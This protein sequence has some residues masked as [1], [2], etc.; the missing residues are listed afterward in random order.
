M[1]NIRIEYLPTS[2]LKEY[3]KNARK[4]DDYDIDKIVASIEEFGFNDPIG[5]WG[6]QNVIV[7]GHGRL[8]AAK[9][10]GMD[11]V[12]CIHLDHLSDA[13]RKAYA[14]AHNKTAEL[15]RWDFGR[16][17]EELEGLADDFDMGD[18]GFDVFP[19]EDTYTED[20][21][22]TGYDTSPYGGDDGYKEMQEPLSAEELRAYSDN[23]DDYLT[24]RRVIITYLPEQEDAVRQM[25]GIGDETVKVVYDMKELI[26]R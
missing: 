11:K 22:D 26:G 21:G 19:S 8:M 1:E 7:E 17:E 9:K 16:L 23:G 13:Q 6:N 12:P 20:S 14:L 3:D 2:A 18:F 25:L 15:S 4:H 24:K 5:V 10:I